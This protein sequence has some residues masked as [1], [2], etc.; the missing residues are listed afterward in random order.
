MKLIVG[1]GNPEEKYQNNRHNIGFMI[2]D[3]IVKELMVSPHVEKKLKSLVFYHHVSGTIFARPQTFMNSSG[4]AVKK[5]VEQYHIKP[6]DLW[7]IHDDLDIP[8]GSYK[9]QKGKGPKLHNGVNS[10]EKKLGT[11]DFWRVRIGVENR[12]SGNRIPGEE[13]V[14]Q[15]FTGEEKKFLSPVINKI[16]KELATS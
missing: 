10:I 12:V 9:I 6:A 5:L 14:L 4:I 15:D 1:L 7:V 3:R 8:L 13:Y 2:I 11:D 16:C